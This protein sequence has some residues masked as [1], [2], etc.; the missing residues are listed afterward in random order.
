MSGLSYKQMV[1]WTHEDCPRVWEPTKGQNREERIHWSKGLEI[2]RLA[3]VPFR[4]ILLRPFFSVVIYKHIHGH[5]P[6]MYSWHSST[7]S[8]ADMAKLCLCRDIRENCFRGA[9]GWGV[10]FLRKANFSWRGD[11]YPVPSRKTASGSRT[12]S[13]QRK[14]VKKSRGHFP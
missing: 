7:C 6:R 1:W 5:T 14:K 4:I 3:D 9:A 8:Y 11:P 12:L 10:C 2:P 13:L